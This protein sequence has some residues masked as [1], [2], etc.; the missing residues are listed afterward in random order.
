MMSN[1]SSSKTAK[2]NLLIL[3]PILLTLQS[4]VGM[5]HEKRRLLP[6]HQEVN[7]AKLIPGIDIDAR[8]DIVKIRYAVTAHPVE[9]TYHGIYRINTRIYS[10]KELRTLLSANN[11]HAEFILPRLPVMTFYPA[12][13]PEAIARWG[14]TGSHGVVDIYPKPPDIN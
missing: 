3:L 9:Q 7:T 4:W 10:E 11:G 6:Q 12:G 13:S 8:T 1:R 14:Q 5:R 2:W